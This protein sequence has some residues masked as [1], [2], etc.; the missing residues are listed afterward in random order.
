MHLEGTFKIKFLG[1]GDRGEI[2]NIMCGLC[3]IV[4]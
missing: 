4:E 2:K 3:W 1:E